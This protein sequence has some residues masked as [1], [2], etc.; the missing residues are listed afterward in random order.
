MDVPPDKV[1]QELGF[2]AVEA[3]IYAT[4]L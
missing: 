2:T 3:A 1:L 4:L